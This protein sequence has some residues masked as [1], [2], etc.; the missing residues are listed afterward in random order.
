MP[1]GS[2]ALFDSHLEDLRTVFLDAPEVF[3][4]PICFGVFTRDDISAEKLSVGHIWPQAI[5]DIAGSDLR[6]QVVLLCKSCNSKAGDHGDKAM[7]FIAEVQDAER[8]GGKTPHRKVEFVPFDLSQEPFHI[9][10]HVEFPPNMEEDNSTEKKIGLSTVIRREVFE[11]NPEVRR[12]L[13]IQDDEIQQGIAIIHNYETSWDMGMVG[14]LTSAYLYAFYTFGYYFVFHQYLQ[15][16]RDYI[17]GSYNELTDDRLEFE[18]TNKFSVR[19]CNE[20]Y[21]SEPQMMYVVPQKGSEL[22]YHLEAS[23]L[24][25]HIRL[26]TF[27]VDTLNVEWGRVRDHDGEAAGIFIEKDKVDRVGKFWRTVLGP[28][29]DYVIEDN[30]VSPII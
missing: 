5:C 22:S 26:P 15:P 2:T 14:W 24:D 4:C 17:L 1:K 21:F 23:L 3:V 11:N 18:A 19:R 12:F 28:E 25:Y 8:R 9:R 13:N 7:Q 10:F 27:D 20:H 30:Q 6:S 29:L 16:I